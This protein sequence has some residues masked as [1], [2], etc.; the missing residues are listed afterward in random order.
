MTF[1]ENEISLHCRSVTQLQ[2]RKPSSAI[3][4]KK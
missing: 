1:I 3:N 4:A 2:I